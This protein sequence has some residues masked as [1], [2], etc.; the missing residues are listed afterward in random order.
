MTLNP[1][2]VPILW[3]E[4]E[5]V[6]IT[7]LTPRVKSFVLKTA[8]EFHFIAGQHVDLRLTAPDGYQ[9]QRSYSIASA[10]VGEGFELLVEALP[11]GEVS[12]FLHEVAEV[13]DRIEFRGPI[14][15]YFN[16]EP[17][18]GG[19]IFLVAGGSGVVPLISILRHRALRQAAQAAL[20]YSARSY[21]EV[22]YAEEL[23]KRVATERNLT[24]RLALTRERRDGHHSGRISASLLAETLEALGPAPRCVYVCGSNAF[25]ETAN[26]LI[27]AMGLDPKIIRNERFGGAGS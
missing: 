24:L 6:Q 2:R 21:D 9:A 22:I 13:G 3:Q 19:P 18:D 20:I 5:I 27:Q 16:W 1:K 25:V 7:R 10:P 23:Q 14:G 4:A 12:A 8:D 17:V 11:E 26:E 15:G